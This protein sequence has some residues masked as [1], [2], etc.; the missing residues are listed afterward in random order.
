MSI[1]SRFANQNVTLQRLTTTDSYAGNTY[2]VSE[3]IAARYEP[4][5]GLTRTVGGDEVQ[6]ESTVLTETEIGL[7]DLVEGSEVRRV[8]PIVNK[9]GAT[10]GYRAY[11]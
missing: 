4:R 1:I 8:E 11:L 9:K 7:G 3:E 5:H 6:A 2:E 10:I